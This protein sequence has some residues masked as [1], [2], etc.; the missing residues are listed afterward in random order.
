MFA[1]I[2]DDLVIGL[3]SGIG[4]AGSPVP[5][6]FA[7]FPIERLRVRGGEVIDAATVPQWAV[8]EEGRKRLVETADAAWPVLTCAWDDAVVPDGAGGWRVESA[9]D[10]LAGEARAAHRAAL[11]S[12]EAQVARIT[13]RYPSAE[14][15]SWALQAMEARTVI[16]GGLLA[17]DALIARRA[18]MKGRTVLEEAGRVRALADAFEGITLLAGA[19]R[20]AAEA[21]LGAADAGALSAAQGG[22]DGA[23]AALS[24]AVDAAAGG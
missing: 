22:V 18:D 10:A 7:G 21:C 23:L 1:T 15:A 6:D 4:A 16:G 9:A 3:G 13:G 5:A 20:E 11:R 19:V 24:A 2:Q 12:A 8:D 17:D 14:V